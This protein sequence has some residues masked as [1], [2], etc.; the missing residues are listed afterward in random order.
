MALERMTR[1]RRDSP[2]GDI[3]YSR[4]VH[5][6][7]HI[8]VISTPTTSS[9]VLEIYV[10]YHNHTIKH[11][12]K[13]RDGVI[14]LLNPSF[15]FYYTKASEVHGTCFRSTFFVLLYETS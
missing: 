13:Y 14:F 3:T 1:L 11:G 9:S 2:L 7:F 4:F 5:L 15:F 10:F 12:Y 6:G 8:F